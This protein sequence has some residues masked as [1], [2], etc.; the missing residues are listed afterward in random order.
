MSYQVPDSESSDDLV[1]F[2]SAAP[3]PEDTIMG[4][5]RSTGVSPAQAT[6]DAMSQE[7][8][9]QLFDELRGLR[10]QNADLQAQLQN[11]QSSPNVPQAPTP[12]P[13]QQP[14]AR[15]RM[16]LPDLPKFDGDRRQYKAWKMQAKM[17]LRID[18]EAIGNEM[19][20]IGVIFNAL[21]KTA[22]ANMSSMVYALEKSADPKAQTLI[23]HLDKSYS[24]PHETRQARQRLASMRQGTRAFVNFIPDF[25]Q[26]L[27]DA[28]GSE[29]PED[30][31]QDR[32]CEA[33]SPKILEA[34]VGRTWPK[35]YD[36]T[37][38][39]FRKIAEDQYYLA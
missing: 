16:R 30:V 7:Q 21:E 39:L 12:D 36:E 13:V 1:S 5:A 15:P 35:S 2:R 22:L 25:E 14:I 24:N 19:A 9:Q 6:S 4:D 26:C 33:V 23:D 10:Q 31:K 20:K 17:K 32:L 37:V 3:T 28:D 27:V 18:A 11:N 34:M 29:W 38:M 8:L